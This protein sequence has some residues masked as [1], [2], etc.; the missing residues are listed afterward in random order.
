MTSRA[1]DRFFAT[2]RGYPPWQGIRRD[3][4]LG[5]AYG[6]LL[7]RDL[8]SVVVA[9]RPR[10]VLRKGIAIA[11]AV[12]GPHEGGD[13]L[14]VPFRDIGSLAPEV[15]EA[16]VDVELEQ[17]DA[18][19]LF[20]A[21][22]VRMGSDDMRLPAKRHIPGCTLRSCPVSRCPA[23]RRLQAWRAPVSACPAFPPVTTRSTP[24]SCSSNAAT[25]P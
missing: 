3:R 18:R 25:T 20:H 11:L 17:V 8:V 16:E 10:R 2:E 22:R 6:A 21:S 7:A 9:E 4:V 5:R 1:G 12:S 15:G 23:A 13:D 19:G 24:S 14:E